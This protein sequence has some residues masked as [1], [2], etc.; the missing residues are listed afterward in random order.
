MR[1]REPK[2]ALEG[3]RLNDKRPE[4]ERDWHFRPASCFQRFYRMAVAE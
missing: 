1:S 3:W 2:T 4:A